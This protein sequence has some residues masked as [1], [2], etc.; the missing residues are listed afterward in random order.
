MKRLCLL[1]ALLPLL[2]SGGQYGVGTRSFN[3]GS[4]SCTVTGNLVA[5]WPLNGC[6]T[7]GTGCTPSSS[8]AA[9]NAACPSAGGVISGTP[10]GTSGYYSTVSGMPETYSFASGGSNT[11]TAALVETATSNVTFTEWVD[12][13]SLSGASILF[14]NGNDGADGYGIGTYNNSCAASSAVN[15]F[16]GG[17][18]CAV[19]GSAATMTTNQVYFVAGEQSS[20]AGGWLLYVGW[21]GDCTAGFT[22]GAVNRSIS[23]PSTNTYV[24]VNSNAYVNH[25]RV[26]NT[27]LSASTLQTMCNSGT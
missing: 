17:V 4:P 21:P 14:Y 2:A 19:A 9:Y 6:T 27:A 11:V 18:T 20:S 12:F 25:V 16:L 5:Y 22:S 13:T 24:V 1:L 7:S 10:G 15:V 26:Y 23:A 3:Q 8:T